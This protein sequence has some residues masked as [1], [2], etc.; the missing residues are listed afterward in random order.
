MIGFTQRL[1]GKG[2]GGAFLFMAPA[3]VFFIYYLVRNSATGLTPMEATLLRSDNPIVIARVFA[4]RATEM[5]VAGGIAA[6][7]TMIGIVLLLIGRDLVQV[8]ED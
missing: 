8:T 4:E 7:L 3:P 6:T 1:N 5:F 2:K